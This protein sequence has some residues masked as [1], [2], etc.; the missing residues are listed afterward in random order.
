MYACVRVLGWLHAC[1]WTRELRDRLTHAVSRPIA[2]VPSAWLRRCA[3]GRPSAFRPDTQRLCP[4]APGICPVTARPLPCEVS[5]ATWLTHGRQA[6]P[7][8]LRCCPCVT[9][10]AFGRPPHRVREGMA[11]SG[12]IVSTSA[13]ARHMVSL[14][15]RDRESFLAEPH[16][17]ALSVSAGQGRGPL[18]VPIWS[19]PRG[20]P[21]SD[22]RERSEIALGIRNQGAER[23]P[24]APLDMV[25]C[26]AATR[27]W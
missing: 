4:A 17:A 15:V 25:D 1:L 3:R 21:R 19:A 16:V 20:R 11:S 26:P 8:C 7:R 14:S 10:V 5:S 2:S 24:S 27:S 9:A 13:Y 6:R 23:R 18:T 12:Q 22:A